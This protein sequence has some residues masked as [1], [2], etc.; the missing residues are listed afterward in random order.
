M[1]VNI[2]GTVLLMGS[3]EWESGSTIEGKRI[4]TAATDDKLTGMAPVPIPPPNTGDP[5][6]C[7]APIPDSVE[8]VMSPGTNTVGGEKMMVMGGMYI[9]KSSGKTCQPMMA[10]SAKTVI[11]GTPVLTEVEAMMIMGMLNG[12]GASP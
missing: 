2:T 10:M 6:P 9:Q 3:V 5:C 11:N 8:P 12:A 4:L 7:I 1:G